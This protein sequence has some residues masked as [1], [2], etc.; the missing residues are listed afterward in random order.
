MIIDSLKK[1]QHLFGNSLLPFP[2]RFLYVERHLE[3]TSWQGAS[4]IIH[5]LLLL[6]HYAMSKGLAALLT[7]VQ[8][9]GDFFSIYT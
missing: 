3:V 8:P 5:P 6:K 1:R 7:S 4:C 2:C 9:I